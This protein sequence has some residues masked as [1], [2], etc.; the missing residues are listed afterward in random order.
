MEHL[1]VHRV[2]VQ[3]GILHTDMEV[4]LSKMHAAGARSKV[5]LAS[6]KQ[7]SSWVQHA[8]CV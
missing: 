4:E 5:C 7:L 1:K 3:L 2:Y 8:V 6:S